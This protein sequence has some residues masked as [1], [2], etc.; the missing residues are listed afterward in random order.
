MLAVLEQYLAMRVVTYTKNISVSLPPFVSSYCSLSHKCAPH[1]AEGGFTG[2]GF[3]VSRCGALEPGLEIH[4]PVRASPGKGIH[5][6]P[7][8]SLWM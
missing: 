8:R 2:P 5:R 6:E 7:C 1:W 4:A 3:S